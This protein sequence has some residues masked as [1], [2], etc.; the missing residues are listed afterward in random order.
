MSGKL[1]KSVSKYISSSYCFSFLL[2]KALSK[3]ILAA[4]T[5]DMARGSNTKIITNKSILIILSI[6]APVRPE[7]YF[8]GPNSPA[9]SVLFS[10][11]KTCN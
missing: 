7:R 10:S 2:G 9:T 8:N 6:G 5:K 11:S 1:F 4:T 3:A